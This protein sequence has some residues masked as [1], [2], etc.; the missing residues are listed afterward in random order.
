MTQPKSAQPGPITQHRR[1]LEVRG[2]RDATVYNRTL[3]LHRL[4][5]WAGETRLLNLTEDQLRDWQEQRSRELTPGARRGEL[6]HAREFYRWALR[7]G[8][9]ADDP[10]ARLPLPRAPR[11]LPRPMTEEDF[12]VALAAADS[13]TA[14]AL[15]LAGY[16]GLRSMEIAQLD[17]SEVDLTSTP[18]AVRVV[19]G[20]GGVGRSVFVAPRLAG[21]LRA[22]PDRR[23]PVIRR[24]DGNRGFNQPWSISHLANR[25]LHLYEITGTLHQ[26]RHRFATVAYQANADIRAVQELLGHASPTTTAIY[27]APGADA[28]WRAVLAA[29]ASVGDAA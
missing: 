23:G 19:N 20:K 12:A 16:A 14:A 1:W 29:G 8:L 11:R 22:L 3:A 10:T 13:R 21:L 9:R 2:L 15:G 24:G 6:S 18:P 28:R 7:E 17:W 27:A 25:H 26:L 4:Q 5:R